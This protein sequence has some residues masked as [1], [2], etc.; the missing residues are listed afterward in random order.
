M[1]PL[2]ERR[3]RVEENAKTL[4]MMTFCG[5]IQ[6]PDLLNILQ[7][8]VDK[9]VAK[10]ET[11]PNEYIILYKNDRR[12]LVCQS[13]PATWWIYVHRQSQ[14][15]FHDRYNRLILLYIYEST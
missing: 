7:G 11:T 12:L 15:R 14:V 2:R 10:E 4:G 6:P 5:Y 8:T 9:K 13:R 1:L 3:G